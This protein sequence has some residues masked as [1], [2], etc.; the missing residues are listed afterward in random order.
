MKS[1]IS[2]NNRFQLWPKEPNCSS[3]LFVALLT[4]TT[5]Y[6]SASG[7]IP[8]HLKSC[9]ISNIINILVFLK[10]Y[11]KKKRRGSS[12]DACRCKTQ[13]FLNRIRISY[14][15]KDFCL[16]CICTYTFVFLFVYT[17]HI[18]VQYMKKAYS[19]RLDP[20][21]IKKI[22]KFDESRTSCITNALQMYIQCNTNAIQTT[23][24]ADLVNL[25]QSQ[26]IDLKRD[27]EYL[28]NQNNALI[29]M[30]TPLLQQIIYK[31]RSHDH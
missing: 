24:N 3:F 6:P 21:L 2:L 12:P 23:Y 4:F 28:M 16:V 9:N 18:H 30:K 22:D 27:K 25:L 5:V 13:L 31:L 7:E 15:Y 14:C 11:G 1:A 8:H 20:L 19:F 29:V 17:L 26:I 10:E